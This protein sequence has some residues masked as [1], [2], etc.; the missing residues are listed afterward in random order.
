MQ[1]RLVELKIC[2]LRRLTLWTTLL[3]VYPQYSCTKRAS[4]TYTGLN[5]PYSIPDMQTV[6]RFAFMPVIMNLNRPL[7]S[8]KRCKTARFLLAVDVT[9]I[10][11]V[12]V[13]ITQ[14]A[15]VTWFH[16]SYGNCL[17]NLAVS[18]YRPPS[19]SSVSKELLN[20][21]WLLYR[22]HQTGV[23]HG[24]DHG[25][26]FSMLVRQYRIFLISNFRRVLNVVLF[27]LGNSPA[28]EF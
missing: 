16:S 25:S 9:M 24:Q 19:L 1:F 7:P 2:A 21:K 13:T 5:P 14:K 3:N 28:P 11:Y 15:C 17:I 8:V 18:I 6:L 10:H 4:C 26:E 20:V 27:L 23:K 12:S 22:R